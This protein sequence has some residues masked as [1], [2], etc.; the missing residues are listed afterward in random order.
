VSERLH[1][2]QIP[3]LRIYLKAKKINLEKAKD[4]ATLDVLTFIVDSDFE[5]S[6]PTSPLRQQLSLTIFACDCM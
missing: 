5:E 3:W 4:W 2:I 6:L 1:L